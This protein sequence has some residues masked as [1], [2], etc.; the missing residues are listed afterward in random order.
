MGDSRRCGVS[1]LKPEGV[2]RIKRDVEPERVADDERAQEEARVT[3][4]MRWLDPLWQWNGEPIPDTKPLFAQLFAAR[5][6][7]IWVLRSGKQQDRAI[8]ETDE[9]DVELRFTEQRFFDAFAQDGEFLGSVRVPD[10]MQIRPSPVF[11][12]SHVWAVTEGEAGEQGITRFAL[13]V[14]RRTSLARARYEHRNVAHA[15]ATMPP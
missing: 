1:L 13:V 8:V 7:R 11:L 14:A 15:P 5:D 3:A 6:G 9:N 10:N 12:T 4:G 2:L